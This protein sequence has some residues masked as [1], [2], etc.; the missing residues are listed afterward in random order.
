MDSETRGLKIDAIAKAFEVEP[1][2]YEVAWKN[3]REKMEAGDNVPTVGL[4]SS[5]IR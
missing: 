1:L 2:N 3:L 5:T 4:R